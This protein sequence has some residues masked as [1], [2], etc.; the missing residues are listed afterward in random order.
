MNVKEQSVMVLG[1]QYRVYHKTDQNKIYSVL[2]E[3]K[4]DRS[5]TLVFESGAIGVLSMF[6][7]N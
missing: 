3:N 1:K 6:L 5:E 2:L 7:F 4:N